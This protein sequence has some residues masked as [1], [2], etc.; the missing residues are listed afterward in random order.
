[1]EIKLPFVSLFSS[2]TKIWCKGKFIQTGE[3]GG[4]RFGLTR[5]AVEKVAKE[6]LACCVHVELE[7]RE[8]K[9]YV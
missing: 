2:L 6:G 1:M 5:D 3:Y 9:S 7:V 4:H 8:C